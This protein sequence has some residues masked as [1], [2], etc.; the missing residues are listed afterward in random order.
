MACG[1]CARSTRRAA[2]L[3][4]EGSTH[5]R[6]CGMTAWALFGPRAM[7]DL[8]PECAPKRTSAAD[9]GRR[10]A[11]HRRRVLGARLRCLITRTVAGRASVVGSRK[12]R[13]D[14]IQ[15][16]AS[17]ADASHRPVVRLPAADDAIRCR[18]TASFRPTATL[19]LRSPLRFASRIT[20]SD[21]SEA[22]DNGVGF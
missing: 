4:G 15:M 12:C 21:G 18:M 2:S 5:L 1:V 11:R 9:P 3:P 10:P 19:A 6:G 16:N 17:A 8:S 7:S 14:D 22:Q 13:P 20:R